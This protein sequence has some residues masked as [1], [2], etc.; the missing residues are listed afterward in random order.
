MSVSER[1]QTPAEIFAFYSALPPRGI[2]FNG[3]PLPGIEERTFQ[4]LQRALTIARDSHM[5]AMIARIA[6]LLGI[7]YL[8]HFDLY[9]ARQRC[10]E[11]TSIFRALDAKEQLCRSLGTLAMI[12][13]YMGDGNTAFTLIREAV[14]KACELNLAP[15][16]GYYLCTLGM[17][18]CHLGKYQEGQSAFEQAHVV[19]AEREDDL[20]NA[21]W[22]YV[23]ARAYDRDCGQHE[24]AIERLELA[25]SMLKEKVSCQ[26]MI[27]ILL[28]LA[29]CYLHTGKL[30]RAGELI[31]EADEKI[32]VEKCFWYRPESYLLKAQISLEKDTTKQ[33]LRQ[34][35]S[36]LAVAG[37]QGDLRILAPLYRLLASV[38]EQ[39]RNRLEDAF[40]SLERGMAAGR[41]QGRFLDLAL[42]YRQ[43]GMHL[44]RFSNRPTLRARGSGYLFEADRMIKQMRIPVPP[45]PLPGSAPSDPQKDEI[46]IQNG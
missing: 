8:E 3:Q 11:A 33:A 2:A 39:D 15:L 25:Q 29:D 19:F 40:D 42:T 31:V 16:S 21:W 1:S 26:P 41:V 14:D 32:N 30:D 18:C 36:G 17:I 23:Q 35:Y 45:I 5:P 20:G 43:A 22:N 38:L 7:L 44:K 12:E 4:I 6:D 24:Q 9:E 13:Y 28:A 46:H 34:I 37:D 10:E 27:E